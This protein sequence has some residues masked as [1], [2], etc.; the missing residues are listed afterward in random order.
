M[1]KKTTDIVAYITWIGLIVAIV[2]GDMNASK[3]HIN[4]AI[5]IWL[6]GLCVTIGS[7]IISLIVPVLGGI[8]G[9]LGGVAVL[10]FAILGLVSAINGEE[11]PLP[12]IGAIHI[13]K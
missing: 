10:V 7:T 11:K 9:F 2:A 6:A 1:N 4:Q 12:L 5:I 3:F 8:V 13:L